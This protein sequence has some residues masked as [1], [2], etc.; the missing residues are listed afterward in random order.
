MIELMRAL[1]RF[2]LFFFFLLFDTAEVKIFP[3]FDTW[4]SAM[5]NC[6]HIIRH[7]EGI[8]NIH[9]DK[10]ILDPGLSASGIEQATRLNQNFPAS[11]RLAWSSHPLCVTLSPLRSKGSGILLTV[12]HLLRV[13]TKISRTERRCSST[14]SYKHTL[15]GRATLDPSSNF[16]VLQA[17]FP[18]LSL[19]KSRTEWHVRDGPYAPDKEALAQRA[20]N[21]Q[22]RLIDQFADLERNKDRRRDIVIV[23]HGGFVTHQLADKHCAVPAAGWRTYAVW[24]DDE[25][26]VKFDELLN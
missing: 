15:L 5:I 4:Q 22:Q 2:P 14:R 23:S 13:P 17:S 8:H 24:Q 1:Q 12:K 7:A 19:L 6:V 25:G 16:E 9:N 18:M 11:M 20:F 26:G 10:N 3:L 21:V